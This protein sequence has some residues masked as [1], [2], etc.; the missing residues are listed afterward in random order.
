MASVWIRKRTTPVGG[1][2]Y[3]VEYR[4]GGRESRIHYGGSFKIMREAR[5]RR[6]W[7]AGELAALR[8]PDLSLLREPT[9]SPTFAE[10]AQR[11]QESRVDVAEGTRLQ[12]RTALRKSLPTLG[13]RRLN[14]ITAQDVADL[15]ARLTT[16]GA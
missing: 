5:A 14:T 9:V 12:H 15:V 1:K 10:A 11:W 2:R 13:K 16:E 3:R 8:V 6:D 4:L 7:V